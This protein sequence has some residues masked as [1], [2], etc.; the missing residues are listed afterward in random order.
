M[1]PVVRAFDDRDLDAVVALSLRAWTPVFASLEEV[2]GPSGL[3]ARMYP[4]GWRT[5]QRQAVADVCRSEENH[6][7]VAEVDSAVAGFVAVRLDRDE[8]MGEISM[9]AV[10]PAHQRGGLG[11]L[12][13]AFCLEWMSGQGM[14]L[15]MVET[16]GD[17]GHAPA[18]QTYEKAG[19]TPLPIVRYFK[20]LR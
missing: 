12:L 17:P 9:L 20:R 13:T 10:D 5:D 2:L 3:F 19:F 11:S 14:A 4:Q 1:E 15:A 8:G 6:V 16:G 7:W 18:R